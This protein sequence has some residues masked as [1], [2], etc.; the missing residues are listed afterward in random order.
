MHAKNFDFKISKQ[1]QLE[2]ACR[3]A[4]PFMIIDANFV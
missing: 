3:V 2:T 4:K 1:E